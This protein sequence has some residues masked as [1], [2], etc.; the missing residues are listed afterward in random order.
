MPGTA[1]GVF[2]GDEWY[3]VAASAELGPRPLARTAL[4]VDLVL[5]RTAA[6]AAVVLRDRCP[7]R[8]A[9]LSMGEVDG[10]AIV[11]PY[12]GMHFGPDGRCARVP[13]QARIP[14][15][16]S[17]RSFPVLERYG[18]VFAWLGEAARAD[19][20]LLHAISAY[21]DPAWGTS[22]GYHHFRASY[23]NILDNLVDPAHTTFVHRRTI[24]N[25]AA[26]EV[27]I[28]AVEDGD[29]VRVGRWVDDAPPVPIVQR[30]A[31]PRGNVDRWQF[32]FLKVPSVSWVDFGA[33]D[34][35][36]AHTPEAQA[37]APYRVLSYAFLTP[38]TAA[39]THYFWF[40]L[41]NIAVDDPAVTAEFEALYRATFDEDKALLEAVQRVEEREPGVAP[42]R[43]ASDAGVA[44]LRR[45]IARR[46]AGEAPPG[47]R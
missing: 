16:A 7:H 18:L 21:G 4:G 42:V 2:I 47:E 29:L 28:E 9:P 45:I 36:I 22:R 13:G 6:G 24:G 5:Y 40:Q 41:R 39:S 38:E 27:A 10:D 19:P 31:A 44:R 25:A 17:V 46:L 20:A 26:A 11:C 15:G 43:I 37:R 30:F 12:H 3:A 8:S 23:L 34:T 35:G 33:F 32:Y 14:P 1:S